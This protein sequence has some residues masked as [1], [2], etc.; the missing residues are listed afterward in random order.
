MTSTRYVFERGEVV[1]YHGSH[2]AEHGEKIVLDQGEGG[3]L[4]LADRHYQ[5]YLIR[6]VS[7]MSVTAIGETVLLCECDHEYEQVLRDTPGRCG[8]VS[9]R[10]TTH[11][12]PVIPQIS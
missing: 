1:D 4:T 5:S 6:R 10:C 7:C 2:A 3:R 12:A 9:C 11:V 8:V